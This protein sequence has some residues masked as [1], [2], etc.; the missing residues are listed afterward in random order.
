MH[1]GAEA[2]FVGSGVFICENPER[3]AKAIVDAVTYWQDP[4]KL[5][6]I[7]TGLGEAMR[8]IEL[9]ELNGDQRLSKRGW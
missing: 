9:S 2:V 7:S 5:A 4:A 6:E 1:L 8:G 3:R